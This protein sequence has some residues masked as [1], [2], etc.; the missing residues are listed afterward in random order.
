MGEAVATAEASLRAMSAESDLANARC[1]S[2][3][4]GTMKKTGLSPDTI[5][6]MAIQLAF[7]RL[8]RRVVSTYE[9]VRDLKLRSKAKE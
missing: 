5:V 9:T 4:A 2:Y 7:Y 3:N 6:Q 8:F 1:L